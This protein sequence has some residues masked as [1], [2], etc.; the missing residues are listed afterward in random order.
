M[1]AKQRLLHLLSTEILTRTSLYG[2]ITC[3]RSQFDSL[4]SL[5]PHATIRAVLRFFGVSAKWLA[6]FETFLQAP[7]K[8][9]NEDDKPRT[10]RRGTPSS[11]V[12]S[13]FFSEILLF[14]L[15]YQINKSTDGE[16]LW[17]TDDDFWFWSSSHKTCVEA[18]ETIRNFVEVMGL[19]LDKSKSAS[20]EMILKNG[21]ITKAHSNSNLPRAEIRWGMIVL[22]ETTGHFTIDQRLVDKHVEELRRQLKD[23]ERSLFAWVQAYST[24]ASVFFTTN[25]GKPAHCFGREHLDSILS[26]HERVQTTLFSGQDNADIKSVVDWLKAQIEQRFG[27]KNVPDGYLFF[28]TSLGGL[29]VKSPFISPLQL[30]E[31]IV[32]DPKAYFQEYLEAEREHYEKAKKSYLERK[33]WEFVR[34]NDSYR[35]DD[36]TQFMPFE[37]YV[38]F[39]EQLNYGY[40]HQLVDTY[41]HLLQEPEEQPLENDGSTIIREALTQIPQDSTTIKAWSTMD[42]YWKWVTMLYGPEMLNIFDGFQIVDTGLLPMGMVSIFRS[43]KVSWQE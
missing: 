34:R 22:D 31:S 23:K 41:K 25:F 26:M 5:L 4:K 43:G 19:G 29:E 1:D 13:D 37:E 17:R 21:S 32:K 7:L 27:V 40:P 3:F 39:R 9:A 18:W 16:L 11:N 15:D 35:P 2:G 36:P 38:K 33:P 28:P 20:A 8:F 10:R 14:C 6:F 24:Y 42:S 12:V 30:R